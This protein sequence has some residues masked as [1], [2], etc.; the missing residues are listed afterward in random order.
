MKRST[1]L[2]VII[3]I[4]AFFLLFDPFRFLR[5]SGSPASPPAPPQSTLAPLLSYADSHFRTPADYIASS[6]QSRDIVFLGELYKISRNVKLVADLIPILYAAGIRNLGI[7]YALSEDQARID[8]LLASPTY[9]EAEARNIT[10]DWVVT[11]GF[12]EYVDLYKAAWKLDRSLPTGSKPFRIVGLSVRQNWEYVK[13]EQ[14]LT[15]PDTVGK[16]LSYGIPDAFMAGVIDREFL[17]KGEKALVYCGT[18]HTF[19]RYRDKEYEKNTVSMKLTETRRAGNIIFDRIG[20]RVATIILHSPWPDQ[21]A[22]S[23]LSYPVDGIIDALI[24]ALPPEKKSAGFDTTGTP[25]G[26]L[27]VQATPYATGYPSLTLADLCDGYVM[28]GPLSE[29]HAVTPIQDFVSEA[30]KEYAVKNFPGPKP[31][32]ITVKDVSKAI[33]DDAAALEKALRQ[34]N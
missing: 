26:A 5:G 19:T 11:W 24:R 27:A 32:T 8:A 20:A 13:S 22:K 10:F 16:I 34:F 15:N 30:Q 2:T 14:D 29:Y 33:M 23:G 6:F 18:Q 4:A 17:A 31:S 21:R 1:L 12:Q 25:L 28:Q 9:S 7:E 3:V